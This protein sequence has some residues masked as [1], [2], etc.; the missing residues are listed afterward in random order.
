LE[1]PRFLYHVN[2]TPTEY[3]P[4]STSTSCHARHKPHHHCT[5][6]TTPPS[7]I[8]LHLHK[9]LYSLAQNC[10]ERF[11][12]RTAFKTPGTPLDHLIAPPLHPTLR[13]RRAI[14]NWQAAFV[15][16]GD[17]G[18]LRRAWLGLV[19]W[20]SLMDFRAPQ[21]RAWAW[22]RVLWPLFVL[23]YPEPMFATLE[24]VLLVQLRTGIGTRKFASCHPV[25]NRTWTPNLTRQCQ[26]SSPQSNTLSLDLSP[27][28]SLSKPPSLHVHRLA[29][30][31]SLYHQPLPI[32]IQVS[33][34]EVIVMTVSFVAA[35]DLPMSS[36]ISRTKEQRAFSNALFPFICT[37]F[38]SLRCKVV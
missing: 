27:S 17:P 36:L 28:S 13:C 14:R 32:I 11:K 6:I 9:S 21:L 34:L 37:H 16:I 10:N 2:V 1:A 5:T 33:V 22:R 26:N 18:G 29:Q 25:A 30:L 20:K 35:L 23:S 8:F 31:I 15:R 38:Q 4:A 7:P 3:S 12:N 19:P 24:D